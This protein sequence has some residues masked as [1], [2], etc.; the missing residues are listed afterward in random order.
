MGM[1]NFR[2]WQNTGTGGTK[3]KS[4]GDR[5]CKMIDRPNSA[6]DYVWVHST[7]YFHA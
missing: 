2:V 6:M 7:G 4:D 1:L 3:L 5:Y